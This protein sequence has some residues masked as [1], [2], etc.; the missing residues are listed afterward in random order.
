MSEARE[1]LGVEEPRD[2]SNFTKLE[3]EKIIGNDIPKTSNHM[4]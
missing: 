2:P 3:Y 4:D 1:V